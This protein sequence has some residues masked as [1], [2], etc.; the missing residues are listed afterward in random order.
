MRGAINIASTYDTPHRV[1]S[2]LMTADPAAV[3]LDKHTRRPLFWL[4][5]GRA[6]IGGRGF[7]AAAT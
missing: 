2:F 4:F 5:R 1:I 7:S 6:T 3:A